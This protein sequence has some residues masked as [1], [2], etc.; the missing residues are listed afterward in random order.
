MELL[1]I[2][3]GMFQSDDFIPGA[4]IE[5]NEFV[6][7]VNTDEG[8][9]IRASGVVSPALLASLKSRLANHSYATS[10]STASYF[11]FWKDK[12][13]LGPGAGEGYKEPS[14]AVLT[15]RNDL[16]REITYENDSC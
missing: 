1:N 4:P 10:S 6:L 13:W 12:D 3:T 5:N 14:G 8:I 16:V 15:T 11:F 9:E 2:G 7:F